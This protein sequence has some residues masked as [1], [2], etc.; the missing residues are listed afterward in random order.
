MRK[1]KRRYSRSIVEDI[2]LMIVK[3]VE[4]IFDG[5]TTVLGFTPDLN[6]FGNSVMISV[7]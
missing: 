5:K 1:W 7:K 3:G 2:I 6:G 4:N